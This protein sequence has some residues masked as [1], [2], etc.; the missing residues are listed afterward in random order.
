MPYKIVKFA[1]H[2]KLYKIKEKKYAKTK[3]KT[4]QTAINQAKNWMR[5]RGERPFRR[6][7]LI[8]NRKK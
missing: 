4:K 8:L 3:F 7:N 6:G 1:N 5:Y 2:Y